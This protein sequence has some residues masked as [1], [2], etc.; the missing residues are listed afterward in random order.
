MRYLTRPSAV[1]GL[2]MLAAAGCQ[3]N[4]ETGRNQWI[5]LPEDQEITVGQDAAPQF[6]ES[7]GGSLPSEPIRQYVNDIGGKLAASSTR[8]NLPW[9]FYVVDSSVINAFALPGGP[10]FISRG[11]LERMDNEAQLAG[12]LGHEVGHVTAR[13]INDQVARSQVHQMVLAGIGLANRQAESAWLEALGVGADFGGSLYLLKFSRDQEHESDWL[14]V[15]YMTANGYNPYGQVQLMEILRDAGG[16]GGRPAFAWL[17]THPLPKKR[18]AE[19]KAHL[20]EK[21]PDYETNPN[22]HYHRDRFHQ[23]VLAPLSNLPPPKH[24]GE[25][26]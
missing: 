20:L 6:L 17:S 12:V 21:Y 26:Q 2:M 11:L 8:P 19:L 22:Y 24:T 7:Y 14:G 10:V 16:S 18:I 13:H 9:Q 1:L 15:K 4:P 3:V 5:V 25:Q 23:Q